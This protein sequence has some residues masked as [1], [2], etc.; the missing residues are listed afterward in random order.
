MGMI[1]S[2]MRLSLENNQLS[3]TIDEG[4]WYMPRL[5]NLELSGN[6]FTGTISPA[7]G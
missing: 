6:Q 4:L 2:L 1:Q 3:G 7:V 5:E